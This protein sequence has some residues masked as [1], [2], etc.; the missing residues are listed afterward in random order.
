MLFVLMCMCC[1]GIYKVI[2]ETPV[3]NRKALNRVLL[4]AFFGFIG[5]RANVF[6][7]YHTIFPTAPFSL[8]VYRVVVALLL[9]KIP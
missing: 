7:S 4:L 3:R 9:F 1:K 8:E 2:R 5:E 6:N